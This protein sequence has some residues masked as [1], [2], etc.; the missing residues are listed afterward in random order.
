MNKQRPF[1]PFDPNKDVKEDSK[2]KEEEEQLGLID[3]KNVNARDFNFLSF[4]EIYAG[5]YNITASKI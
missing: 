4:A 1:A 3:L 2:D 5:L